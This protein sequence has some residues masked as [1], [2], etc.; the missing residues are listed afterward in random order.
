[1]SHRSQWDQYFCFHSISEQFS[2]LIANFHVIYFINE[3]KTSLIEIKERLLLFCDAETF[4]VYLCFSLCISDQEIS[5]HL[6]NSK[7]TLKRL[8]K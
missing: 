3:K 5:R 2:T 1:M 4:L 6:K 8:C 7:A